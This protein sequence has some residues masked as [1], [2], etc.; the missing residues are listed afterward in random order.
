MAGA[1]KLW[2]G[3][4][5]ITRD[6]LTPE[7]VG[8]WLSRVKGQRHRLLARDSPASTLEP[9]RGPDSINDGSYTSIVSHD[10]D[11]KD[12]ASAGPMSTLV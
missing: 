10:L 6:T 7:Q 12:V 11:F 9:R 1:V 4:D 8:Y 5:S 3:F 2:E